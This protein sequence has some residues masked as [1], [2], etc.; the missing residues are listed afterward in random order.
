MQAQVEVLNVALCWFCCE[1]SWCREWLRGAHSIALDIV[2]EYI[3]LLKRIQFI[4][5][6]VT[7]R[8]LCFK[9]ENVVNET[10][11]M[12]I[13]CQ[14]VWRLKNVNKWRHHHNTEYFNQTKRVGIPIRIVFRICVA[15]I[16]TYKSESKEVKP[17]REAEC[18][19]V[20]TQTVITTI[21][22]V[23]VSLATWRPF[24]WAFWVIVM[25]LK[26]Y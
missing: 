19:I 21:T 6:L 13:A 5:W 17:S 26:C 3:S 10:K 4:I 25:K 24:G 12:I 20:S 14:L 22:V 1:H 15:K 9:P 11:F 8:I 16:R 18:I 7:T 23:N 2:K